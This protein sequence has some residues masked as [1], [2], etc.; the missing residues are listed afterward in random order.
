MFAY[1]LWNAKRYQEARHHFLYSCDGA[2]CGSMLAEFHS[3]RGFS[4]EVD[5]FIACTVLQLVV[6][7]KHIVA[8][9]ALQ[10]YAEKHPQIKK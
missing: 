5:L 6:L 2:G 10:A 9:R 8:A 3:A 1:N 7:R 4:R